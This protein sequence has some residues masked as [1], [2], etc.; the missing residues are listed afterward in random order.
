MYL[1]G[2]V[3]V[4]KALTNLGLLSAD[5]VFMKTL[6]FFDTHAGLLQ[7]AILFVMNLA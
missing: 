4:L 3:A 5:N 7:C 6:T 2:F 1:K